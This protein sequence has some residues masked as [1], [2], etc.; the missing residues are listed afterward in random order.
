MYIIKHSFS[1]PLYF[2]LIIIT[3]IILLTVV[4]AETIHSSNR[5][6]IFI[7]FSSLS[8]YSPFAYFDA[9]LQWNLFYFFDH[10]SISFLKKASEENAQLFVFYIIYYIYIFIRW[11]PFVIVEYNLWDKIHCVNSD[12][13]ER[14]PLSRASQGPQWPSHTELHHLKIPYAYNNKDIFGVLLDLMRWPWIPSSIWAISTTATA[15]NWMCNR[16]ASTTRDV[17]IKNDSE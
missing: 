8:L 15:I 12:T 14:I 16:T 17:G 1:V 6:F 11:L 10:F 5:S 3:Y 4:L 9:N 2:S 13:A 7:S